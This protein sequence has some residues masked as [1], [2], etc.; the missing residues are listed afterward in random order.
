LSTSNGLQSDVAMIDSDAALQAAASSLRQS[1]SI[2]L[3]LEADGF[4]RYPEHVALI[5]L[6]LPDGRLLIVDPLAIDDPSPLGEV[7]AD[8]DTATI[9]H[10]GAFDLRSLD[11]DF[12]FR[13]RGLLDTAI[14]AQFC[15][16]E[17]TGLANVL[18][19]HIGVE[20]PKQKRYQRHDWSARPLTQGALAYAAG[21]VRHLHRLADALRDRLTS[22]G[23][24]AWVE[25]ECSRLEDVR[26][27]PPP[28]ADESW[29]SI[30]GARD[31]TGEARAVLRELSVYRE[32]EARRAGRP[33]Y[34]IMSNQALLE[35]SSDPTTNPAMLHGVDARALSR[36]GR[37]LQ[38]ALRRGLESPPVPWPRLGP[39]GK[40]TR[41]T[42]DRL[43][44]LKAWRNG[45][46]DRLRLDCGVVWPADHLKAI[47]LHPDRESSDLDKRAD[48]VRRWQWAELGSSLREY[49]RQA[50]GDGV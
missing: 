18:A 36:S 6:G 8:A 34:R 49:R 28:P 11:R 38:R 9:I 16:S 2:G 15:G 3:D 43:K 35:L 30:K 45:E 14:A 50:L 44:S 40:W 25:E 4:H 10:S 29:T 19:E 39:N 42:R 48:V 27:T 1:A 47:A 31:L 32:E 22:L 24:L 7:L 37:R 17:R 23:R 20:L 26:Y 46:A 13:V 41:A 33:P 12:G 5:Q 21:D